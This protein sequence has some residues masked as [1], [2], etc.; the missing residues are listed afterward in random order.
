LLHRIHLS[1]RF[2]GGNAEHSKGAKLMS[3][4]ARRMTAGLG[5]GLLS[6]G[7]LLLFPAPG[8][9]HAA[10]EYSEPNKGETVASPPTEVMANY[11]E[12]LSDGSYLRVYDP[13]GDQ[14]DSG[15]VRIFHDE[16]TV[17][18]E[19]NRSGQYRVDWLAISDIDPH[20]TRGS[21]T[22][23]V[24]SGETCPQAQR[25]STNERETR[26]EQ[27][28]VA[29]GGESESDREVSRMASNENDQ[30][31]ASGEL[32]SDRAG[33]GDV[34]D[35]AGDTQLNDSNLLAQG[36]TEEPKPPGTFD[37]PWGK[38]AIAWL[39]AAAI[40]AVGGLIYDGIMGPRGE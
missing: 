24:T 7:W 27:D 22:F 20:S 34:P 14:V 36:P 37:L 12:P 23:T 35:Q 30:A 32:R 38:V 29:L 15:D 17:S 3:M 33:D 9:A 8:L 25:G 11:T 26:G 5:I 10:Y 16:M 6:G 2:P 13:C 39:V 40:G 4:N 31:G 1:G 18:I 21:F 28:Q 19:S